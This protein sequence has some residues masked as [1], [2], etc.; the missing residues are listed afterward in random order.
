MKAIFTIISVCF[1]NLISVA[2]EVNNIPI[3]EIPAK[4]VSIEIIPVLL[5]KNYAI[6]NYGQIT[7]YTSGSELKKLAGIKEN[8]ELVEFKTN[9]Q[10]LNYL[11]NHGFKAIESYQNISGNS[12]NG[13]DATSRKY[14]L[15]NLNY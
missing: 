9:I 14:L 7:N 8:S 12:D 11:A 10:V 6:I 2:Q 15:E 5:G 4:Y 13:V 1:L 3:R